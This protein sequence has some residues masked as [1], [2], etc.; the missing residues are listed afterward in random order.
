MLEQAAY[1]AGPNWKLW[2]CL[3]IVAAGMLAAWIWILRIT[4]MPLHSYSGPLAPLTPE[5]AAIRDHLFQHVHY[6]SETIGQ[7]NIPKAGALQAAADYIRKN[8]Q[9]ASY[10]ISEQTFSA[11]GHSVSNLEARLE[12]TGA[13]QET[14]VVGAHYDSVPGSPGANDNATGV[15]AV[16]EL[17]RAL[18]NFQPRRTLRFVLFVN[19]EPPYFQT[20]EMGSL[21]YARELRRRQIPVV[22]MISLE[23]IGYYA[24]APGSQEYPLL[25]GFFYPDRGNFIGFVGNTASRELVRRVVRRFRETTKFPSEGLA[26]PDGLP[27]VGWSDHWSFWQVGVPAIM[28]TD[29]AP[30]RYSYYHTPY[31]TREHLDY[32]RMARVVDGVRGVVESLANEN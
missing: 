3:A 30:F 32:E 7:R 27:G 9:E 13:A 2:L 21:V 28:V 23:T 12:G 14:V 26:A 8:L 5:Q 11:H 10:S 22:A 31:D 15:A 18:R 24:E 17:A 6:L 20:G 25:M 1:S 16:L 19:E 4:R 29:T